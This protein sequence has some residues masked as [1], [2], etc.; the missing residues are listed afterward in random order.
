MTLA[1]WLVRL[2]SSRRAAPVALGLA[3]LVSAG[4]A[5][6]EPAGAAAEL[7]VEIA[8]GRLSVRVGGMPLDQVLEAVAAQS[9]IAITVRGDAGTVRPQAFADLPVEAA[10]RRLAGDRG[11]L[12]LFAPAGDGGMPGRLR[13]VRVYGDLPSDDTR[14]DPPLVRTFGTPPRQRPPA[15]PSPPLPA[16]EELA[17]KGKSERLMAI[18]ALARNKDEAAVAMLGALLAQDADGMVRR[19]AATALGNVGGKSAAAAL[20]AALADPQVEVRIQ[21]MRGLLAIDGKA[22]AAP[23]GELALGDADP[24]LRRQAVDL[25]ATL[26]SDEARST[27]R[28]AS[29]DPDEAVRAAAEEALTRP[30]RSR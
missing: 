14:A 7:A 15:A 28:L 22:A 30:R 13:Q 18:R 3:C 8:D 4:G 29:S 19:I 10:I 21:A 23:L 6:S 25:L 1:G 20:E 9:E 11:L 26:R 5:G 27:I 2:A 17:T 16:Y 24:A 12:M